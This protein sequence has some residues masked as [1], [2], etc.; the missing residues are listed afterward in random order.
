[1]AEST[2]TPTAGMPR[3]VKVFAIVAAAVAVLVVV[4]LALGHGPGQHSPPD[5]VGEHSPPAQHGS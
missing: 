2:P 4:L 3:W 5:G 1:M